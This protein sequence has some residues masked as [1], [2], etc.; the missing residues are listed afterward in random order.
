[1]LVVTNKFSPTEENYLDSS[2]YYYDRIESHA[3]HKQVFVA[4]ATVQVSQQAKTQRL[5]HKMSSKENDGVEPEELMLVKSVFLHNAH[6][7]L[8]ISFDKHLHFMTS[9]PEIGTRVHLVMKMGVCIK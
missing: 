7:T 5:F 4:L 8:K 3:V 9:F 2:N 6:T 1:M